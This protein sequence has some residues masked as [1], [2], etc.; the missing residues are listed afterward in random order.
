MDGANALSVLLGTLGGVLP[1]L[2]PK[3]LGLAKD[4]LARHRA[5]VEGREARLEELGSCREKVRWLKR[6]I[7]ERDATIASMRGEI[8]RLQQTV[9]DMMGPQRPTTRV[10]TPIREIR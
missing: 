4:A 7:E 2:I 3:L 5:R 6:A 1:V 8:S 9:L 10:R